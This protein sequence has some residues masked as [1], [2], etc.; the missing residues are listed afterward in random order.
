MAM[1]SDRHRA[2]EPKS[3]ASAWRTPDPGSLCSPSPSKNSSC[4]II[5][6]MAMSC[7]R[8]SPLMT[9]TGAVS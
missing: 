1:N 8:L 6:F 2:K 9:T 4:R 5:E 3:R 7:S